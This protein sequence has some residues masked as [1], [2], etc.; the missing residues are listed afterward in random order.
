[1]CFRYVQYRWRLPYGEIM[2]RDELENSIECQKMIKDFNESDSSGCGE[3]HFWVDL[4]INDA[5]VDKEGIVIN[6]KSWYPAFIVGWV[7]RY[8]IWRQYEK[9]TRR[10]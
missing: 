10:Y 9:V 3:Y 1:M 2:K 4:D 7:T 5:P 6:I 8:K